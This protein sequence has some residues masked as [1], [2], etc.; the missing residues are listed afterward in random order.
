M[1][2]FIA[3]LVMVLATWR[4]SSL[5]ARE[6]GPYDVLHKLRYHLGVRYNEYSEPH[7]DKMLGQL[8]LCIWCNSIWVGLVIAILAD[9]MNYFSYTI[10][11]LALSGGAILVE[12]FRNGLR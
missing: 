7:S 3:L 1:P 12:E 11:P 5:L 6:D 10:V 4:V 9:P 8:V 2:S